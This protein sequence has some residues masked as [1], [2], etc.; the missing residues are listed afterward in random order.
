MIVRQRAHVT[1][2]TAHD[3]ADQRTEDA[4]TAAM[5]TPRLATIRCICTIMQPI[6]RHRPALY[7]GIM[8]A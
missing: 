6:S 7:C 2:H 8:R 1:R 3:R 4:V 5:V